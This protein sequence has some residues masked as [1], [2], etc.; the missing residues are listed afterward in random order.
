L[1]PPGG[2]YDAVVIT[3]AAK[4]RHRVVN[5]S[6]D[7]RDWS[8]PGTAAIRSRV[9]D[10]AANNGIVIIRDGGG[11]RSQTVAALPGII[12]GLRAKG[13]SFVTLCQR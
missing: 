13:Y 9:L 4:G 6:I 5:W 3:L 2:V 11:N 7:P 1:R 8:R 12:D 10:H